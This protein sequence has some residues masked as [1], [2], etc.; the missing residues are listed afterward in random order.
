M[1]NKLA[2]GETMKTLAHALVLLF[3]CVQPLSAVVAQPFEPARGVKGWFT[4]RKTIDLEIIAS[5]GQGGEARPT[6]SGQV[7]RL[8]LEQAYL[9]PFSMITQPR[10]SHIFI[11][12]DMPTGLPSALFKVPSD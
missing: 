8:R 9:E 2:D 12:L 11:S 6:P 5:T 1:R 3:G 7:L 10:S 4:D